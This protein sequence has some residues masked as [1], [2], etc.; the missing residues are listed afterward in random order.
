MNGGIKSM[1][2]EIQNFG[3]Y[4]RYNLNYSPLTIKNYQLDIE[5]FYQYIFSQ[6]IDVPEVDQQI[7]RE[8]LSL[9][10]NN[11]ISKR[12]CNRKLSAL[13]RYFAFLVDH[14][15]IHENPFIF[16]SN[17]KE[18]IRLPRALYLEEIE[19]LFTLNRERTDELMIR[20]QAIIEVLYATGVRASEF[21]NIKLFDIEMKERTIRIF[22]K[23][24]KERLVAF[25]RSARETLEN[26]L[27]NLRPKL[28]AKN[29]LHE[30]HVFLNNLGKP[31]TVRGLELILADIDR[32][33]GLHLQLHPHIFR[34][35]IATHLLEGG[36]DL[37]VI[38][39]L[40]GH[41]SLNTTQ[42]Y[43][44]VTEEE[45]KEEF[46]LHHPRARKK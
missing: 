31:L 45:M 19:K 40:L 21:V 20:D 18:E 7:I 23:G 29:P 46:L 6:G 10:M 26:Y 43:T 3:D 22:G 27:K 36:A 37:R 2:K 4:L 32:K 35:S 30:E 17:P 34:H 13:R 25:S 39:D 1:L 15:V 38:Q 9:L 12:S 42:I 24:K 16:V 28:V 5:H 14:Q 11:E 44:H 33:T 8:Y 41:E